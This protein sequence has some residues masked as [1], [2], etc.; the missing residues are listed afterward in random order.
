MDEAVSLTRMGA[1][2]VGS[3]FQTLAFIAVVLASVG[4]YA[5]TAFGVSQ[6][7][8]EIGVR[9]ALGARAHRVIWL[10][11]RRTID[12]GIARRLQPAH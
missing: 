5:L 8:R 11:V 6:R 4:L 9:M 1:R 10:F 2:M 12:I 7:T 3:W